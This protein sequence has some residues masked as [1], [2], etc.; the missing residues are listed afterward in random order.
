MLQSSDLMPLLLAACP[1]CEE[2]WAA[3]VADPTF[4]PGLLYPHLGEVGRHVIALVGRGEATELPAV[5]AAV[6]RVLVEGDAG[7]RDAATLGFLETLQN[8]AEHAGL[9]PNAFVQ[10]LGPAAR[11]AWEAINRFWFGQPVH[12]GLDE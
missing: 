3:Y 10:Y 8:N 9:D 6:E 11:G 1:S 2:P 4:D 5:F 12:P 7:A